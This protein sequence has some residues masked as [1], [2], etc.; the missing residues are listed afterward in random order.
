MPR[1]AT[2]RP[3]RAAAEVI[4]SRQ[5]IGP[6]SGRSARKLRATKWQEDAIQCATDIGEIGEG[7]EQKGNAAAKVRLFVA[8]RSERDAEPE[9]ADDQPGFVEANDA[10]TR[11]DEKSPFGLPGIL[12]ELVLNIDV[13][14]ECYLVGEPLDENGKPLD[15]NAPGAPRGG[16]GPDAGDEEDPEAVDERWDV[17][18]VLEYQREGERETLRERQGDK[19]RP[20][21]R[22]A[23]VARIW[24]PSPWYSDEAT[25]PMRWVLER[26]DEFL[27]LSRGVRGLARSRLM[28]G[29]LALPQGTTLT[30]PTPQRENDADG[31]DLSPEELLLEVMMAAIEDEGS[32]ASVVPIL[33]FLPPEAWKE[34]GQDKLVN[35]LRPLQSELLEE[36]N[37]LRTWIMQTLNFP[38]ESVT[39]AENQNHWNIWFLWGSQFPVY[40]E[41]TVQLACHGLT[42]GFLRPMMRQAGVDPAAANR[43]MLWYDPSALTVHPNEVKDVFSAAGIGAVGTRYV[44]QRIG[45]NED[46][47]PTPEELEVMRSMKGGPLPPTG[48]TIGPPNEGEAP[49]EAAPEAVTAA[50]RRRGSLGRRLLSIDRELRAR[51]EA[52]ATA[53]MNR[54]LERAGARIRNRSAK[55]ASGR[56]AIEGEHNCAVAATL[57]PAMVAALGFGEQELVEDALDDFGDQFD[58]WTAKA[59]AQALAALDLDPD[60]SEEL[61]ARQEESRSEAWGWL[62]AGLLAM[63]AARLYDPSPEA[64]AAGEFDSSL[65]V[66]TGV[67]REAMARAGGAAGAVGVDGPSGGVATGQ[68]VRLA[69]VRN[70]RTLEGWRWV[71]GGSERP[72]EPHERLAGHE[73]ATWEDDE[74]RTPPEADWIGQAF[75]TPGDHPGCSCDVEAVWSEAAGDEAEAA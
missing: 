47:A 4:R 22:G 11:L 67:I 24:A 52:A 32:A 40:T 54:A 19:G 57:G 23:Y 63:A 31:E 3:L 9:P 49:D 18:S 1:P 51:L 44:R 50:A 8:Y 28:A 12:K 62:S 59:Q 69:L 20:L 74:L 42:A 64:P 60:E 70:G 26:C 66:P 58:T 16:I 61:A 5:P 27:L 14:G 13:P 71:Y 35:F 15:P 2:V 45:A 56:I 46:D 73:F 38:V 53:A 29:M 17:R 6:E 34:F 30:P 68:L 48:T 37:R 65:A 21:G 55:T 41:P 10:L 36:R 75:M 72:F 25:S 43:L 33:A 7:Y 39:G